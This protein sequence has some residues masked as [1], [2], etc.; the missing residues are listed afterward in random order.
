M[1][2]LTDI[3]IPT[4]TDSLQTVLKINNSTENIQFCLTAGIEAIGD[5]L[6]SVASD[7]QLTLNENTLSDTGFLLTHLAQELTG[8]VEIQALAQQ[9]IDQLRPH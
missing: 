7:D 4:E 3:R 6:A 8:L 1:N 9:R 5:L 2:H